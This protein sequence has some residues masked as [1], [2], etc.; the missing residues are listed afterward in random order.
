M[1]SNED[2]R[3]NQRK[4]ISFIISIYNFFCQIAAISEPF[5]GILLVT[6]PS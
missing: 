2:N 6:A 3:K 1:N 5:K 4:T